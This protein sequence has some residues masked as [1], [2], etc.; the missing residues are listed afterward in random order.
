MS[1]AVYSKRSTALITALAEDLESGRIIGELKVSALGFGE[2][3]CEP[4]GWGVTMDGHEATA[5]PAVLRPGGT[6]VHMLDVGQ[7]PVFSGI[8]WGTNWKGGVVE[9]AGQGLWSYF[10]GT[11]G[12]DRVYRGGITGMSSAI[13]SVDDGA[14][15]TSDDQFDVAS[16]LIGWAQTDPYGDLAMTVRLH[17]TDGSGIVRTRHYEPWE[18]ISIGEAVEALAACSQGFEFRASCE[19]ESGLLARY[20]DLWYPKLGSRKAIVWEH[21]VDIDLEQVSARVGAN[22][23]DALGAGDG[24][25]KL[26]RSATSVHSGTIRHDRVTNRGGVDDSAR[27]QAQA[28]GELDRA[29]GGVDAVSFKLLNWETYPL[30]SWSVGDRVKLVADDGWLQ[31]SGVEW[32]RIVSWDAALEGEGESQSM[33]VTVS[34]TAGEPTGRPLMLPAAERAR[35]A[36][37]LNRRVSGLEGR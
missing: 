4:G 37:D 25:A 23:V 29:D 30:G 12:R 24:S 3:L 27:L 15:F 11:D 34:A 14:V 1:V 35:R 13:S 20:L 28:D 9:V 36:R 33:V 17:P 26:I 2:T 21:G 22:R 32:W 18:R 5:D 10:R 8:C 7:Q 31:M 6:I 16:D 19:W